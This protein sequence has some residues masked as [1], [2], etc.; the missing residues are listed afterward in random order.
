MKLHIKETILSESHKTTLCEW[1]LIELLK[2]EDVI[3]HLSQYIPNFDP[4]ADYTSYENLPIVAEIKQDIYDRVEQW[5]HTLEQNNK[6]RRVKTK[7][8]PDMGLSNYIEVMF[9][10]PANPPEEWSQNYKNLY[11]MNIKISDHFHNNSRSVTHTENI[12]GKT[13]D[14]VWED[15]QELINNQLL[16][17]NRAEEDLDNY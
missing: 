15:I 10:K 11:H 14:K 8:S 13:L 17:I 2:D 3:Q 16:L 4:C 12:V 7:M 6:I 5:Q 1:L 9:V